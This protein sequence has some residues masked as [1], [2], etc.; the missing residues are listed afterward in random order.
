M[1]EEVAV[2]VVPGAEK[3]IFNLFL[4]HIDYAIYKFL[5]IL[6][7]HFQLLTSN[8]ELMEYGI[9]NITCRLPD[10]TPH[11]GLWRIL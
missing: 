10:K 9:S 8:H 1:G 7:L 4:V 11:Q 3:I 6:T 2:R 5:T